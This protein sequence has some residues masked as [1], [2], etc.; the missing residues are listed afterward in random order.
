MTCDD[1]DLF[2]TSFLMED[3]VSVICLAEGGG[4]WYTAVGVTTFSMIISSPL[5]MAFGVLWASLGL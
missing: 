5:L 3:M 4:M 1:S 2:S